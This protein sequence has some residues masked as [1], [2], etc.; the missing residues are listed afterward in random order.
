MST[1]SQDTGVLESVLQ[2]GLFDGSKHQSNVGGV[3]GLSQMRVYVESSPVHLGK[4]P[5]DV[6]GTL[7]D[8]VSAHVIREL[9]L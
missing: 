9:V 8:V 5:Q 2:D 7:V 3:S 6:L 4:T 1:S